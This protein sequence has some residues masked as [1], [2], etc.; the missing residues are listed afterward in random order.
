MLGSSSVSD[1]HIFFRI[2]I[3][4]VVVT[5]IIISWREASPQWGEDEK[6]RIVA[7]ASVCGSAIRS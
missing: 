5:I 2:I 7:H 4:V 1:D 3:I 6:L